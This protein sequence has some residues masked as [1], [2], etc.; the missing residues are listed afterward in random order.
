MAF[1]HLNSTSSSRRP[2]GLQRSIYDKQ[3]GRAVNNR[4]AGGRKIVAWTCII[5][6]Y[7]LLA[8]LE[9]LRA[10]FSVRDEI[11]CTTS[12]ATHHIPRPHH[13]FM[14]VINRCHHELHG[15]QFT[16]VTTANHGES[17]LSGRYET[18]SDI[19]VERKLTGRR[20][21]PL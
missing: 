15:N 21:S 8:T 18:E 4:M 6:K 9:F 12:D 20:F 11:V 17:S 7:L 16:P 10:C 3:Q 13:R 1:L 5:E 19:H 2:S 14:F